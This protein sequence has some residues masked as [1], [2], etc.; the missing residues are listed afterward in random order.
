[1]CAALTANAAPKVYDLR[2]PDGMLSVKVIVGNDIRYT[3]NCDGTMLLAPSAISMTLEDGTVYG[4]KPKFKLK[5]SSESDNN[6]LRLIDPKFELVFKAFDNGVAYRFI[7]KSKKPFKVF[8]EQAEFALP[9]DY[10]MYVPYSKPDWLDGEDRQYMSQFFHSFENRYVHTKVSDWDRK[11]YAFLPVMVEAA[12][13]RK[14][15]IT[16]TDLT[17]YPGLYLSNEDGNTILEG[18]NP[19]YPK[20]VKQAGGHL[21][22]GVVTEREE[23]IA[24]FDSGCAF[25]WRIIAVSTSDE[26]L[27]ENNL[28]FDLAPTPAAGANISWVKPGKVAW[29]WWNDWNLKG[30]DFKAGVNNETY[31][32]YIDF[33][34]ANGIEYVILDEGWSVYRQADLMQVVPEIDLP[35]LIAYAAQRNVGIILWAGYWAFD[36]NMEEICRHYSEM[37]V[38]G[39]KVDFMDRDD[40]AMVDFHRRAAEM[41]AKYKLMIDF[42]GTYKPAG[43]HRTYPNVVNYEGVNGLENLKWDEDPSHLNN[44]LLIP[45][46]RQVAG[47]MDYTQGAMKNASKNN[48]RVVYNEPMSFGTRCHQLAEYVVFNSPLNMLCDTPIN[49][50]AEQESTDF[51][52]AIPTVWDEIVPLKSVVGEYAVIAKRKGS[53]WYLGALNNWTARELEIDLSF[54][55]DSKWIMEAFYDGVNAEENGTDYKKTVSSLSSR[56]I[57][58]KLASGGGFAAKFVESL[59]PDKTVLLYSTELIDNTD[60]VVGRE[61]VSA[62]FE[63][64]ELNG[65]T[66]PETLSPWND[67]ANINVNARVDIYFPEK[68]NGKMIVSCPGGGYGYVASFNE[69]LYVADWMLQRGYAVAVVKYRMPNGHWQV[70]LE[71]VQNA[72]RY[73]RANA[74]EWGI[75]KIGVIG[76]SAGGHLAAQVSNMFVDDL[77]RPDFS[78]LIYPVITMEMAL[79]HRGTRESLLGVDA[80]QDLVEEYSM[81]NRV[82][83]KTPV[84]FLAHCQNDPAVPVVNAVRYYDALHKNGVSP[85]AV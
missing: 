49:Y 20:A 10:M 36:R 64:K 50:M 13:G 15:V 65:L 16:E 82:S 18:L 43:L 27:L 22:H 34:S 38:K 17:N 53:V 24:K 32:Y 4:L 85:P 19:P 23:Y 67:N 44:D 78:I 6:E 26:Q 11:K 68:P 69:G 12:D 52:A 56:A 40:Q 37:G 70:P 14:M 60:P 47:P 9:E 83:S 46:I 21:L 41:T 54:L 7:S 55:G 63:M 45:F 76:F 31:K 79:T 28:A 30:V 77:T 5:T 51:I 71:D 57:T 59:R 80:S 48:F 2:S 66:G 29:E 58:V 61:I 3:V 25:P 39:F 33:A 81:E 74:D 75:S 8:K 35:E 62:G 73:C 42:H 84:T 1:M 72:F